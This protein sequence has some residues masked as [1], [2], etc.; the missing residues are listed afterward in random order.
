MATKNEGEKK[1]SR[2]VFDSNW[3]SF[4]VEQFTLLNTEHAYENY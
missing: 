4:Q 1:I 3:D 2:N